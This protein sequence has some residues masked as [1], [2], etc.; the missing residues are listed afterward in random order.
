MYTYI[1]GSSEVKNPRPCNHIQYVPRKE[2]VSAKS[3][4]SDTIYT[5]YFYHCTEIAV[6]KFPN[7]F[8]GTHCSFDN[9]VLFLIIQYC[10]V[11][12]NFCFFYKL[13]FLHFPNDGSTKCTAKFSRPLA[14]HRKIV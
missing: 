6:L 1:T 8:R 7:P 11:Y 3:A 9:N 10:S 13:P 12:L 4:V 2:F 14:V 5:I